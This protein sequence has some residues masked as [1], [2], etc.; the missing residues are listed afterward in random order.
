MDENTTTEEIRKVCEKLKNGK[1]ADND[2]IPYEMYKFGRNNL[3]EKMN[4][5]FGI[6]EK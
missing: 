6:M 3:L 2:G 1:A 4:A 5:I